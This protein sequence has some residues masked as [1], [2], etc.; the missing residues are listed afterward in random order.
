[1][2][3]ELIGKTLAGKYRVE[4]LIGR[5][6][7]AEVYKVWD[8]ERTVHLALKLLREDLARDRIFLRRFQREA[9]ALAELQHPNIVRFYGLEQ[10]GLNAFML[11]DFVEGSDLRTEIFKLDGTPMQ[12]G[13]ILEILRPLCSALNYAHHRGLVHCD[14]KPANVMLQKNGTV[15]VADFGIARMTDT[16]TA[17]LVGMGTPAYMSPEQVKG[18]E[19][20]PQTDIYAL[21]VM[22]YEMFS[23]GERPFTG[24]QTTTG[25]TTSE[26]VRWE[27]LN[28]RPPSLKRFR[29]DFPEEVERVVMRCLEKE[30]QQRYANALNLL[31]DLVGALQ[32]ELTS[33][34]VPVPEP[35]S[36]QDA[37]PPAEAEKAPVVQTEDLTEKTLRLMEENERLKAQLAGK[38]KEEER[39]GEPTVENKVPLPLISKPAQASPAESPTAGRKLPAWLWIAASGGGL[40][41]LLLLVNLL[42]GGNSRSEQAFVASNTPTQTAINRATSKQTRTLTPSLTPT[43]EFGIGSRRVSEVDEMVQVYV[44]AGAFEMGSTDGDNDEE[45]VHTVY[46]DAFWIDQTEVTN[47]MYAKCVAARACGKPG[48]DYYGDSHYAEHPVVYVSWDDAEDYCVWAGRDLPTEAQWE[49]AARGTDGRIYPWG[50]AAPDCSY[51][52]YDECN[53]KTI[54]AGSLAAGASP[55]EALDMAGNVWEWI[56]DWYD[57][58]DYSGLSKNTSEEE[59][60]GDLRVKVMRGGSWDFAEN[61]LRSANRNWYNPGYTYDNLGFRC[62]LPAP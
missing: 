57:S 46:L 36:L 18:L 11:I 12:A 41:V 61:H 48:G 47:E 22:L 25:G 32:V 28:L 43:A 45:P 53:G 13:R 23:G 1:M 15:L 59:N 37:L 27:Q 49:K 51:A 40:L 3:D 62:V 34:S 24:E 2:Q 35:E 29:A 7:M 26:K 17:T 60:T 44:P 54:E 30:P 50:N 8:Q 33:E 10:E 14:M 16:A 55:Y 58:D 52:N 4:R 42:G 39:I 19:T 31:N 21:G 56:S 38:D 20:T 9:K 6:G 5:G